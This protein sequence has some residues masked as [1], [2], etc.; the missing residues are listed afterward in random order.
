MEDLKIA[1]DIPS[2]YQAPLF[3]LRQLCMYALLIKYVVRWF[4]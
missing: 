1:P 2:I 4:D 3:N